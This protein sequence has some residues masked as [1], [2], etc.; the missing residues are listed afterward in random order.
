MLKLHPRGLEWLTRQDSKQFIF[1]PLA[2]LSN[3]L[4]NIN[5]QFILL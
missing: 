2:L 5:Q 4:V 1:Y 3:G